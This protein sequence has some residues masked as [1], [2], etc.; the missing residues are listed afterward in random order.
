MRIFRQFSKNVFEFI[1]PLDADDKIGQTYI[2]EAIS[3]LEN[4]DDVLVVYSKAKMFGLVNSN[5]NLP[6][7]SLQKLSE[8]NIIFCSGIYRKES[9][10]EIGGYDENMDIALEDW[11]FW[12]SL[13]KNGGEVY[14]INKVCFYYRIKEKSRNTDVNPENYPNLY[15]YL[16]NKHFDFFLNYLGSI[17]YFNFKL[18]KEKNNKTSFLSIKKI[19]K[20]LLKIG[21]K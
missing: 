6:I 9:W 20:L 7:F 11:E 17:H 15:K 5:W 10:I 12:I 21:V 3:V 14:R 16:E 13:L 2:E 4:N 18:E 19:K 1:L 8:R